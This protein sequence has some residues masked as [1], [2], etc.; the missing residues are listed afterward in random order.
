MPKRVT[1]ETL[2]E[3]IEELKLSINRYEKLIGSLVDRINKMTFDGNKVATIE[4]D[5]S[6]IKDNLVTNNGA[7]T[8]VISDLVNTERRLIDMNLSNGLINPKIATV[9]NIID[10]LSFYP[11]DYHK[12]ET[13]MQS[14]LIVHLCEYMYYKIDEKNNLKTNW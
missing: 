9:D 1:V 5:I 13:F 2:Q 8:Q 11:Y 6:I 14:P 3:E 4:E 10:I 7:I 12:F